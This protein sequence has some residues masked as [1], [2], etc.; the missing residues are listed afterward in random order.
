MAKHY[1]IA[2]IHGMYDIYEQV[3]EKLAPDDIVYFLGDAGDRGYDSWKCI[4]AI[5]NDPQ[6]IYLK[7]NH[8][9]LMVKGLKETYTNSFYDNDS[10]FLWMYN[11]GKPTEDEWLNDGMDISWIYK[12][13]SLPYTAEYTNPLGYI[14]HM[15]HAGYT[16]GK[17]PLDKSQYLWDRGHFYNKWNEEKY[18]K[19]I[20]Q[21]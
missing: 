17:E 21:C 20:C 12:L 11:G 14:F 2:D 16:C 10:H 9:D 7:G 5:Y 1:A 8:E 19:D 6:W 18:N 4:K 15:S 13:D 3:K